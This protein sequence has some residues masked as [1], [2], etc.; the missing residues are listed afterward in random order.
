MNLRSWKVGWRFLRAVTKWWK[1]VHKFIECCDRTVSVARN[2]YVLATIYILVGEVFCTV[3][4]S[5][6][7][8]AKFV[9]LW[10]CFDVV[11]R[12][13]SWQKLAFVVLRSKAFWFNLEN[14]FQNWDW[15]FGAT[16]L[17]ECENVYFSSFSEFRE[18]YRFYRMSLVLKLMR[19]KVVQTMCVPNN[20]CW[21]EIRYVRIISWRIFAFSD[22]SDKGKRGFRATHRYRN[23]FHRSRRARIF[24]HVQSILTERKRCIVIIY[25]PLDYNIIIVSA[26]RYQCSWH[27]SYLYLMAWN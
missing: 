17:I 9:Q 13:P 18:V 23:Y 10:N 7:I 15:F 6:T 11:A 4:I 27:Q 12:Y 20:W 16:T 21:L 3:H 2:L 25:C 19:I 8:F 14:C 24:H 1:C 22:A 26:F 5:G